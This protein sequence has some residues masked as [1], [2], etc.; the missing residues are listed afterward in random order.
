MREAACISDLTKVNRDFKCIFCQHIQQELERALL[1]LKT[2]IKIVELLQ[3]ETN[4]TAPS[5]TV[6]T[7]TSY[8]S[9]ALSSDLE[10]NTSGSGRK[11]YYT[12][13]K[14]NKQ[15]DAQQPQPVPTVVNYFLLLDNL[16]E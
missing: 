10:N 5:T 2:A 1:E 11:V 16:Q 13:R 4:C 14:Y 3:E 8:D 7:Q 15:P 9:S 6:N 12:R